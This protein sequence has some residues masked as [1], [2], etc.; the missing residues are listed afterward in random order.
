M[1][2]RNFRTLYSKR[3]TLSLFVL[4]VLIIVCMHCA[5]RHSLWQ[6]ELQYI[7]K[8][9]GR[10]R[11]APECSYLVLPL[12]IDNALDS[13]I[14]VSPKHIGKTLQ[15]YQPGKRVF[16]YKTLEK[17]FLKRHPQTLLDS[18]YQD[19]I[20]QK[21]LSLTARDSVWEYIPSSYVLIIRVTHGVHIKSFEGLQ[22]RKVVLEG[23]LW[24]V[25]NREIAWHVRST[26]HEMNRKIPDG[27][28]IL[29]GIEELIKEIPPFLAV[30]NEENW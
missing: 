6:T 8:D 23:E 20:S 27:E 5:S 12:I 3:N 19:I 22:K 13:S 9:L 7:M 2:T 1:Y 26:G 10:D 11:L 15:K 14:K 29:K 18:F 25:K 30:Q 28:F 17:R 24:Y 4:V 21:I 16:S